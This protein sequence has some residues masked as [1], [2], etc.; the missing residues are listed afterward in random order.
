MRIKHWASALVL[1]VVL[2]LSSCGGSGGVPPSVA[3]AWGNATWD[4]ATWGP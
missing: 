3:G 2:L 1:S 4:N